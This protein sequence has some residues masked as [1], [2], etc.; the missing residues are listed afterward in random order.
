M[1]LRCPHRAGGA[2]RNLFP[3]VLFYGTLFL[4]RD[5]R[6][7]QSSCTVNPSAAQDPTCF[8]FLSSLPE[9]NGTD[10]DNHDRIQ[11]A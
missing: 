8:A 1:E 10:H 11:T 9:K 2:G 7:H 5:L 6:Y 4:F 3:G